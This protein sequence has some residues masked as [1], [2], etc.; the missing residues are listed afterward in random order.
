ME[1]VY[2]ISKFEGMKVIFSSKK[3]DFL[4]ARLIHFS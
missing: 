1:L 4:M 3:L 2:H